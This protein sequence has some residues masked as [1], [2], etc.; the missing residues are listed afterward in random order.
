LDS[1]FEPPSI[2]A[3]MCPAVVATAPHFTHFRG[4]DNKIARFFAY[5]D[6]A[7]P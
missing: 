5:S 4:V 2:L 7:P 6:V 1:S 3:M